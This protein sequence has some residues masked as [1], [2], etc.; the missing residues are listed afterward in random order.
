VIEVWQAKNHL[1]HEML[2]GP[3]GI[4]AASSAANMPNTLCACQELKVGRLEERT[5]D[6]ALIDIADDEKGV[7]QE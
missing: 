1:P 7:Y 6:L 3:L 4:L 2:S 5:G